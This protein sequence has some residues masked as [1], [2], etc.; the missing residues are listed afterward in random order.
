M[1]ELLD[2]SDSF[3]KRRPLV[4]RENLPPSMP[5]NILHEKPTNNNDT[6]DLSLACD[7]LARKCEGLDKES[8]LNKEILLSVKQELNVANNKIAAINK[9]QRQLR[10][11]WLVIRIYKFNFL[12][13]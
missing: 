7:R 12:L 8:Q 11:K 4:D 1:S 9:D 5:S 6:H 3:V 2:F 10:V 13:Q